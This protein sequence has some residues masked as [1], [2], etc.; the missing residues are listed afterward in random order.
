MPVTVSF[1]Q[2]RPEDLPLLMEMTAEAFDG[3]SIDQ[4]IERLFGTI[5]GH[6]WGWRKARHVEDD[7]ARDAAGI[8]VAQLDGEMVGYISTRIDREAGVGFIPNLVVRRGQ[9]GVC[10][11][12]RLIEHAMDHFRREVN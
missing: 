7:A 9:R 11:G 4:G 5:D 10:I 6:E 12:R 1:R 8:F 3:V 2:F